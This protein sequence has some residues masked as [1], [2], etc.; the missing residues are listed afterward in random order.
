MRS[1]PFV[2]LALACALC[3]PAAAQTGSQPNLVLTIFGGT[4]T[5]HEFWRVAKQPLTVLGTSPS[6]YDTLDLSRTVTS[7]LVLGAAATYFVSPRVGLHL[8]VSYLGLPIE[9]T[10]AAVYLHPD[11]SGGF[12]DLRRNGQVCD[13]ITSQP[14]N[15]GAITVFGGVTLR[16]A[17]RGAFSPYVRGNL[18][19]VTLGHSTIEM[20][21]AFADASGNVFVRQVLADP[22]AR[23][24]SVM[25]GGAAGFTSPLGPGYQFRLELRD[26]VTSLD[27]LVG[28]ANALHIGPVAGKTYHHIALTLGFDVVLEQKRGRRY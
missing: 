23:R 1:F 28:P 26:V 4:V 3:A 18:G 24:T 19:L 27:R 13:D 20:A 10:C 6:Q 5:G 16:A 21:G 8:E 11:S 9:T 25:F 15:G 12:Q 2:T 7:S 14:A 22:K 17:P